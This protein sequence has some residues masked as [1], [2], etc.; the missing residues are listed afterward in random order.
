MAGGLFVTGTDTDVGKTVV[1]CALLL[2]LARSHRRVAGFKPVAAGAERTPEGLR[3]PDAAWLAK[4]STVSLGYEQV[5]P[6]ALEPAMA[7]HIAA[8]AAGVP[9]EVHFLQECRQRLGSMAQVI[10]TEGAGGWLVPLGDG[11]DMADL[12]AAIGDPV[13]LVVGMKLGCLNHALLTATSIRA[14]GC[15][16]AGWVANRVD[17]G[18]AAFR[19]NLDTLAQRLECP[20]LGVIPWL[21]DVPMERKV[22]LASR[23]M[24]E[25]LLRTILAT[26]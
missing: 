19:E 9:L 24:D 7:P 16:L 15:T 17:P 22:E 1:A 12:A 13:V 11:S 14:R 21:G 3:N 18:M 23:A 10:V 2:A 5:N 8:R 6:V 4:F 25:T 20:S 26:D